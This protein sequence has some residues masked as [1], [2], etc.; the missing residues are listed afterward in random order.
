MVMG[1]AFN[2]KQTREAEIAHRKLVA[3][4]KV[5]KDEFFLNNTDLC[6]LSLLLLIFIHVL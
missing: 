2:S 5:N 6:D 4:R 1:W 3:S